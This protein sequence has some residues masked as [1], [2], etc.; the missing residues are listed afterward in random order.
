MLVF[1]SIYGMVDGFFVSNFV[2]KISFAA[3]N[4]VIPV[5]MI[6]GSVGFMFGTGSSALIAKT[7]G[8][9]EREEANQLFSLLVYISIAISIVLAVLAIVFMR[10]IVSALGAEGEMLED[11]IIYGRLISIAVPA[12]V[13]Q[14][15]FQ[16]FFATAENPMVNY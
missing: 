16:I 11:S 5:M 12:F 6:L 3:V 10:P 13:L 8:K 7:I 14:T 2:G 9:G 1:T 15:E 4:F